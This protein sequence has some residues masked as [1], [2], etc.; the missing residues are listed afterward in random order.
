MVRN[1]GG[2]KASS[3]SSADWID[4]DDRFVDRVNDVIADHE[5]M[6]ANEDDSVKIMQAEEA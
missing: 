1:I 2:S 6:M 5:P 4:P 3:S